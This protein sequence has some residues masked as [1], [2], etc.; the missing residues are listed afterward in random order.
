M[1][2]DATAP[3]PAKPAK[4]RVPKYRTWEHPKGSGI[5]IAEMPNKTG[6]RVYGV[7]YQVRIP[8]DLL[9]VPNK[10][11][12]PQRRTKEEAERLAE[13]R[14][15]AL[16]KHGTEFSKIPADFQKQAAIAWGILNE[17]NQRTKLS[18]NL[19]DTV[20]AG[21]RI[22]S[23]TGG[24]KT[25]AE[26]CSELRASKTGRLAKGELDAV[27][28]KDFRGRSL[29]LE[30]SLGTKLVS[31][32]T[33]AEVEGVLKKLRAN[34]AQRSVLNYRNTLAEI[35]RHAK[36]KQYSPTNPLENFTREDYKNLGGEKPEQNLDGIN[37]L[38]VVEARDLLNAAHAHAEAGMLA[39]V[40]CVH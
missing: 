15:I 18:L 5:K 34:L 7:S 16:K 21:M 28:E 27:T 20:K 23:P 39:T 29:A 17:H 12:M 25:F 38:S 32:I 24:L 26:V 2:D 6:G 30:T 33:T 22:L 13:E 40:V 8:A 31:Q 4:K 19:I 9:G 14:F 35:F 11:E 37:I 3:K 10:R 36:A 1:P